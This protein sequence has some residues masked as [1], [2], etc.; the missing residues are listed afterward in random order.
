MGCGGLE[1]LGTGVMV[2]V[3]LISG[4]HED[5]C[6]Y[7][8]CC[9]SLPTLP[10][11]S[12]SISSAC[13]AQCPEVEEP[14]A[15]K[16]SRRRVGG[17]ASLGSDAASSSTRASMLRL[18]RVASACNRARISSDRSSVTVTRASLRRLCDPVGGSHGQLENQ[19]HIDVESHRQIWSAVEYLDVGW[20]VALGVRAAVSGASG[21]CFGGDR[22][23]R[24]AARIV[25][26]LWASARGRAPAGGRRG[27]RGRGWW[28]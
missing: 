18:R 2:G 14:I 12:A 11:P 28:S 10:K 15:T 8:Q 27:R 9:Q 4:G 20:A 26:W 19:R 5:A 13:D 24:S 3:S 23:A 21:C 7:D 25:C 17:C 22:R 6:V 16:L 1:Q